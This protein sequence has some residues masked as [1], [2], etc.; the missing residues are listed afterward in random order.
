MLEHKE[1]DCSHEPFVQSLFGE[2][3]TTPATEWEFA[4]CPDADK[5]YPGDFSSH[6]SRGVTWRPCLISPWF[7]GVTIGTWYTPPLV[8]S[9]VKILNL[10]S[11]G[12]A[13]A[14]ARMKALDPPGEGV[15]WTSFCR[16]TLLWLPA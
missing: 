12:A 7:S 10:I 15:W 8:I 11:P 3:E 5:K 14:Q 13:F 9:H 16:M 4:T 6:L 2:C 1:R